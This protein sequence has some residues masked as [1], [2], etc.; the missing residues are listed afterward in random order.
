[1]RPQGEACFLPDPTVRP[2]YVTASH[3]QAL[4]HAP[5]A[6]PAGPA[7]PDLLR[8]RHDQVVR[9]APCC[10]RPRSHGCGL[11]ARRWHSPAVGDLRVAWL[12]LADRAGHPVDPETVLAVVLCQWRGRGTRL[13]DPLSTGRDRQDPADPRSPRQRLA[14]GCFRLLGRAPAGSRRHARPRPVWPADAL[15]LALAWSARVAAPTAGRSVPQP[16]LFA[17]R[18]PAGTHA[19]L[20]GDLAPCAPR[21]VRQP[22]NHAHL[23]AVCRL[24]VDRCPV[25]ACPP[26]FWPGGAAAGQRHAG[27]GRHHDAWRPGYIRTWQSRHNALAGRF[28]GRCGNDG[29]RD[30]PAHAADRAGRTRLPH[31]PAAAAAISTQARGHHGSST[32]IGHVDLQLRLP[33]LRADLTI[34]RLDVLPDARMRIR[35]AQSFIAIHADVVDENQRGIGLPQTRDFLLLE[36]VVARQQRVDLVDRRLD[37]EQGIGARPYRH[38]QDGSSS[39]YLAARQLVDIRHRGRRRR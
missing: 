4:E 8:G 31:L 36:L 28:R 14:A 38:R 18:S 3:A 22:A 29:D 12:A 24:V 13:T 30:T 25:H 33:C 19:A 11:A 6:P 16:V 7:D 2:A 1:A 32:R 9:L 37:A 21:G 17:H 15:R 27:G 20:C 23:V 39:R 26:G 5:A 10:T 35:I 34:M